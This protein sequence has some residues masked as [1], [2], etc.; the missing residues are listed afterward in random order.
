MGYNFVLIL[1][2]CIL[3]CLNAVGIYLTIKLLL[4]YKNSSFV[5][6]SFSIR[7]IIISIIFYIFLDNNWK[8]ALYMI[9]GLTISKIIFITYNKLSMK[10][11]N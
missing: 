4:K 8:N 9:I 3:G 2:G 6:L 5:I 1:I 10:K 7:M 11:H